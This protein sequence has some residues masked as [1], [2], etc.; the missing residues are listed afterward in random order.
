MVM[1][2]KTR[3]VVRKSLKIISVQLI[4]YKPRGD[5]VILSIDSRK[6]KDIGWKMSKKNI[7][8]AYLLGLL[9][10]KEAKKIGVKEA[11]LDMG[12]NTPVK[13][14]RIFAVLK[15]FVDAGVNVPHSENIFPSEK[16]IK[17]EHIAKFLKK[18]SESGLK[19]QFS[20]Y[21]KNKIKSEDIIKNFEDAKSKLM[22]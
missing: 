21:A 16:R 9:A 6:L 15:G 2:K 11:I 4:E 8:S 12:L 1:S 5:K 14:S 18:A 13:G 7:S 19:N 20:E 3:L 10:G 22:V 17:G